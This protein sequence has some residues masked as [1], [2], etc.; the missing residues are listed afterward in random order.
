MKIAVQIV[1]EEKCLILWMKCLIK[2]KS[3]TNSVHIVQS[4]LLDLI[5]LFRFMIY[6]NSILNSQFLYL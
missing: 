3:F 2:S 1:E 4:F 5:G 6:L